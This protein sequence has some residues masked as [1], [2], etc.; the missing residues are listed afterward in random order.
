MTEPLLVVCV[1]CLQFRADTRRIAE[2]GAVI[3]GPG[4]LV[5]PA[6]TAAR[7]NLF[8][9]FY[10]SLSTWV[11]RRGGGTPRAA[12]SGP[13]APQRGA[14]WREH[15]PRPR[16]RPT[17]GEPGFSRDFFLPDLMR[18]AAQGTHGPL[19]PETFP[20]ASGEKVS[21]RTERK[22]ECGSVGVDGEHAEGAGS[23]PAVAKSRKSYP[24]VAGSNPARC[25]QTNGSIC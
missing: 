21:A 16:T 25:H 15:G 13:H 5:R 2:V 17:S 23:S 1:F 3:S 22:N 4:S 20:R 24:I 8:P 6:D 18:R 19:M 12:R 14:E 11:R 9:P 10:H 7:R